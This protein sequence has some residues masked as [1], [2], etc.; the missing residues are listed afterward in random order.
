MT[1]LQ[2][3]GPI[4]K[5]EPNPHSCIRGNQ[6]LIH[7][8]VAIHHSFVHSWDSTIYSCIRDNQSFI[9]ASCRR[10]NCYLNKCEI[11][12]VQLQISHKINFKYFTDLCP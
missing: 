8:F 3:S 7:A 2:K 5:F 9:H 12:K 1:Q 11:W 10:G 6:T 4:N